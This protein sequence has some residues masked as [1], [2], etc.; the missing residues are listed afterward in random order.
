MLKQRIITKDHARFSNDTDTP[1]LNLRSLQISKMKDEHVVIERCT[2]YGRGGAG[3]L[4]KT[5]ASLRK[6][7][8]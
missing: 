7:L 6:Q 2:S 4:R 1:L 3:N 8:E 5:P